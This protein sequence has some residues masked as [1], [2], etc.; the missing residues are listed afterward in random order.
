MSRLDDNG[1]LGEVFEVSEQALIEQY[2]G[3]SIS[4]YAYFLKEF[5]SILLGNI[6][7]EDIPGDSWALKPETPS[8]RG[9]GHGGTGRQPL[10]DSAKR[11][12]TAD[13]GQ[14]TSDQT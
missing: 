7:V 1:F 12:Y 10:A 14:A 2:T 9:K 5:F 8:F 11:Q 4:H 13:T 6:C 3:T